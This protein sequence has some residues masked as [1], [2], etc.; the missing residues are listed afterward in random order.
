MKR[1]ITAA[2][3]AVAAFALVGSASASQLVG[4]NARAV[5]LGADGSGRALVT[6]ASGGVR[7]RVLAWGA[8]NARAPSRS[9]PQ[10]EFRFAAGAG[11]VRNSCRPVRLVL[12]WL[13]SACQAADGSYWALQSWQRLLP[14]GGAGGTPAQSVWELRLSH[15]T[16]P[17]ALLTVR[18]GWS[19][20]RFLQLYGR[21]SYRGRPVFG[22]RVR[23]GVPLDGYGRNLYLDAYDSDL[24][25]GWKRVNSFLAH[26]SI[27]AFCYGFYPHG[28]RLGVGRRFR[29]TVIG[30]GVTPDV[31]WEGTAPERYS[32]ARDRT[33]DGDLAS[34]LRGDHLCHPN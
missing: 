27:G 25:R 34:L 14:N 2:A 10:V 18:F 29:A 33:A 32:L 6:F 31:M 26:G 21:Y 30:P 22:Y 8:V 17:L 20:R 13:V 19:Y 15:W 3:L 1:C 16:E 24:G 12:A 5:S 9:V 11:F 23:G 7:H 4:K 28:G